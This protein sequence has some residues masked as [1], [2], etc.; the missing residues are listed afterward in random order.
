MRLLSTSA[1]IANTKMKLDMNHLKELAAD[2]LVLTLLAAIAIA[3]FL[4]LGVKGNS[5]QGQPGLKNVRSH[6]DISKG[7]QQEQ[8][9]TSQSDSNN[10]DGK[11]L[12][13]S[14]FRKY[15]VLKVTT[16]SHNTKLIRFEL[17]AAKSLGLTIG[18]HISV[19][20]EV[21]G[22]KVLRA[23]TPVSR[24]DQLG[25]FDLLIKRYEHGKLSSFLHQCQAGDMVDVRGPVG[26]FKYDINEHS[27]IGLIA[28]GT[29][30][31]PCLQLLKTILL[32]PAYKD[33]TTT[34]TLLYQNRLEQDILLREEIEALQKTYFTRFKL[35]LFLSN[36]GNSN[37][38]SSSNSR[39]SNSSGQVLKEGYID[40]ATLDELQGAG[41]VAVCGPSGFNEAMVAM[42]KR[43]D[44][45]RNIFVW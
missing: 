43:N 23:Y 21:D 39:S 12:S 44:E 32:C 22:N 7:L 19:R 40:E 28:G 18:R 33:D 24:I 9:L 26:R 11:V 31:T 29:G 17:P 30:I 20:G 2:P 42:L 13:A 25:Y 3:V 41:L 6:S 4:L 16:V 35:R 36:P 14:E 10:S 38:N 45:N 15:Q 5:K 8:E 37:S 27:H 34:F 1:S